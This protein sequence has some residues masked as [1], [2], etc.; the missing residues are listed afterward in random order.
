M[1]AGRGTISGHLLP[2]ITCQP[3]FICL[4]GFPLQNSTAP[5]QHPAQRSRA[6]WPSSTA[7]WP[8]RVLWPS[9]ARPRPTVPSPSQLRLSL[10]SLKDMKIGKV[11]SVFSNSEEWGKYKERVWDRTERRQ[12]KDF[13]KV[14]ITTCTF[15]WFKDC[16][17]VI[18]IVSLANVDVCPSQ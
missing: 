4:F 14:K 2:F 9:P 13:Q 8:N 7:P 10:F 1:W 18:N 11:S 17:Y 12:E 3:D 16:V 6:P 5:L 15:V